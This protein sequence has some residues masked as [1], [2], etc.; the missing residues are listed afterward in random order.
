M[1]YFLF[2]FRNFY[3]S[4]IFENKIHETFEQLGSNII[5]KMHELKLINTKKKSTL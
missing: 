2:N 5:L 4:K 3:F 1:N